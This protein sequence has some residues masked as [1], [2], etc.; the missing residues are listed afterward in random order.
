MT[1]YAENENKQYGQ[2]FTNIKLNENNRIVQGD[3]NYI[4]FQTALRIENLKSYF[5]SIQKAVESGDIPTEKLNHSN[6]LN[7]IDATLLGSGAERVSGS[8]VCHHLLITS[9]SSFA[10]L[11]IKIHPS[12]LTT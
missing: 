7:L 8:F 9:N 1:K 4:R 11:S 10:S 2:I 5:Q 12:S 6:L 3:E